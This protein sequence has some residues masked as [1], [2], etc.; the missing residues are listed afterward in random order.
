MPK[1]HSRTQHH[2]REALSLEGLE[3]DLAAVE[4]FNAKLAVLIT[5]GVGTMACAYLFALVALISLPDALSAG[6]A[7]LVSWI[8]QTFLQ[9]V[10]LSI[11][12]VGQRVQ[13]TASDARSARQFE[14]TEI[15]LDRLDTT[16]TGGL[17]E[18]LVAVR[19]VQD[20]TRKMA[21]PVAGAPVKVAVVGLGK[22]PVAD[23]V[24]GERWQEAFGD[25]WPSSTQALATPSP[26]PQAP[27]EPAGKPRRAKAKTSAKT[28]KRSPAAKRPKDK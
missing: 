16:T 26:T 8:A 20:E 1:R 18:V 17:R 9:L 4:G 5:S 11:I 27:K 24:P 3:Q 14:D 2:M 22:R 19:H 10:L 23:G 15:I 7:Q 12:L 25:A 6:R 28:A 13:A 21:P